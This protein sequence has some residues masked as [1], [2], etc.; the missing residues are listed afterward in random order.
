MAKSNP[1]ERIK[2]AVHWGHG[3]RASVLFEK[4]LGL[5]H[6]H[7]DTLIEAYTCKFHLSDLF[8]VTCP[9]AKRAWELNI[10]EKLHVNHLHPQAFTV[11][12]S[13]NRGIE[14]ETAGPESHGP[15]LGG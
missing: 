1:P 8:P 9:L 5:V 3:P 4:M 6:G 10:R 13:P 12:A 14:G 15:C 7:G 2:A 11:W